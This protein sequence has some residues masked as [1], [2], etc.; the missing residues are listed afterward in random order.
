MVKSL[1]SLP[2]LAAHSY[3]SFKSIPFNTLSKFLEISFDIE[4]NASVIVYI[5]RL[6]FL[7]KLNKFT[8]ISWTLSM[9]CSVA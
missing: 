2:Y 3:A 7:G 1:K 5:P 4:L 9:L 6:R 8:N